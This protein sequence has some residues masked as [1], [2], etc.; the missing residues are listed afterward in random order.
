VRADLPRQHRQGLPV[1]DDVV[2]YHRQHVVVLAHPQDPG[3]HQRPTG[4]LEQ[5]ECPL[6]EQATH[7]RLT[8]VGRQAGQIQP[9]HLQPAGWVDDHDRT[10]AGRG[11]H[12]PHAHALLPL[13]HVTQRAGQR[14]EV[15][16]AAQ[17]VREKHHR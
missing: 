1:G 6:V 15:D 10:G 13:G 2:Q 16:P 9:P 11:H 17:P 5:R 3:V 4:Q 7:P 8:F 12:D 14:V